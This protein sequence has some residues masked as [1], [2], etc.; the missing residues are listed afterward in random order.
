MVAELETAGPRE[1]TDA[2]AE[3]LAELPEPTQ[4]TLTL[5]AVLGDRFDPARVAAAGNLPPDTVMDTLEAAAARGI[6]ERDDDAFPL[7]ASAV[8]PGGVHARSTRRRRQQLHLD[9]ATLAGDAVLIPSITRSR[10][11]GTSATPGTAPTP[12]P[13][14]AGREP[15]VTGP[16]RSWPGTRPRAASRPPHD[17]AVR[18]QAPPG[19][20][21]DLAYRAGVA[22]YRNSDPVP[23][24]MLPRTGGGGVPGSGRP[25]R[26]R[27]GAHRPHP[28]R[29]HRRPIRHAGRARAAGGRARRPRRPRAPGPSPGADGG[30]VLA[31]RRLRSRA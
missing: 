10:S 31:P 12:P 13:Y 25:E 26:R 17:A 9:I 11:P 16:G 6:L 29:A 2:V 24:R 1:I 4:D 28:G 15:A 27:A 5:A 19:E 22:H 3:R 20:F 18:R 23:S 14:C 7:R 30:R 8:C 21:A